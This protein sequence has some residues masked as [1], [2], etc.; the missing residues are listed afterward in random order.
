MQEFFFDLDGPILD[1]SDKYYRLYA[2]LVREQGEIPI[3]KNE[4]WEAKRQRIPDAEILG[5]SHLA[6]WCEEFRAIRKDRIETT[7]YLEYDQVWHGISDSLKQLSERFSLFLVTLRSSRNAL[8]WQLRYLQ[9]HN[10]FTA[11][12]SESGD[13][14][15]SDKPSIKVN[16]I[17]KY[18][19]NNKLEGWFIGDTETDIRAGQRLGL[20]TV[21]V[22]FGIRTVEQLNLTQP[23]VILKTPQDLIHWLSQH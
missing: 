14:R 2:D 4:Y 22:T 17:R 3:P 23:D 8:L 7:D 6:K 12:L 18:L 19:D 15:P 1:V 5:R 21:A 9:L 20:R 16:L 13:L 11:I 10:Y